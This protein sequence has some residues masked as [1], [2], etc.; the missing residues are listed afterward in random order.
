[1][2]E[3][4]PKKIDK[5]SGTRWLARNN[6]INEIIEQ[7]DV[8]KLHF[9]MAKE[10]ERCYTAQLY[11][12][13]ADKRNYLYMVFLQKT[14]YELITVNTA[15]QSDSANSLKLMKDLVNLLK[16]YLAI[17]ISPIR[18]QQILNQEFL[19][20]CFSDYVM[21]GDFLNFGNEWTKT[22][23]AESY[24]IQVAQ[25]KNALG[26]AKFESIAKLAI[27][28]LSLPFSNNVVE[29]AFSLVNVIKDKLRNRLLICS[30]DAILRVRFHL[31]DFGYIN[32]KLIEKMLKKFNVNMCQ[33]NPENDI[34]LDVSSK[35]R[36]VLAQN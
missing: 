30:R 12:M 35:V 2:N 16:N 32:F 23:D 36:R 17:L 5:L 24:W 8:L 27:G 13:F 1:M 7:W 31:M 19:S 11:Q 3:K 14:L 20:F 15:S 21:S 9:E 33:M 28:L 25:N 10:S 18:L 26:Q 22:E 29:K 6:A 34:A 4:M